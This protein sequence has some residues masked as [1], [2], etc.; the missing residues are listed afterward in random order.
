MERYKDWVKRKIT[1]SGLSKK[2]WENI[3][4]NDKEALKIVKK[5]KW[6]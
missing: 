2:A 5:H 3:F 6:K 4:S 1:R